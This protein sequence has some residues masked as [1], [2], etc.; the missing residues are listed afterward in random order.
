MKQMTA[1]PKEEIAAIVAAEN[2]RQAA[3]ADEV[4]GVSPAYIVEPGTPAEIGKVL[5]CAGRAGLAVIPRGGGTKI[6]WGNPPRR[7]DLVLSTARLNRVLEHAWGDMTATVEAGC[8]VAQLQRTLAEHGQRLALD[9]LWPER[10]TIGG[11]LATNDSGAL[12]ARFG[13]LRDLIIGVTV[14]LADGTLAKSGGKVV[15]NVAGY[16]LPKLMTGSLG[17]LGVITDAVFRLHPLPHETRSRSF[18]AP[19]FE[20]LCALADRV[21]DSRLAYSRVQLR[22]DSGGRALL[23]AAFEGT[24]AGLDAQEKQLLSMAG[25]AELTDSSECWNAREGLWQEGDSKVIASFG[26][27]PTELA[28]FCA[29]LEKAAAGASASWKLVAQAIGVGQVSLAAPSEDAL[30][31]VL[32]SVR[33]HAAARGGTL[34]VLR[35]SRSFKS[36]FSV[37]GPP[38]DSL[39]LMRHVKA[40]LDPDAV[41]NPGRFVGGI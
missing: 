6:G 10:A 36:R 14:A 21:R 40:Q 24:R 30:L 33:T 17:T 11:I 18:T 13:S 26:V 12:R 3:Q 31:A 2:I 7:A 35:C 4:D 20:T 23:D 34:V 38:G 22:A 5:A 29:A 19:S 39:Q 25:K 41:L 27:L 9:A 1:P 37:W 16:D 15:K 28:G 8:T 32:G